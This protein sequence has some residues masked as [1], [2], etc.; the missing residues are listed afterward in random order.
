[1]LDRVARYETM[2][3]AA[4]RRYG[5]WA[6]VLSIRPR[7]PGYQRETLRA[8][9][10]QAVRQLEAE[11]M[12][13]LFSVPGWFWRERRLGPAEIEPALADRRYWRPRSCSVRKLVRIGITPQGWDAFERGDFGEAMPVVSQRRIPW[14]PG[15]AADGSDIAA[16]TVVAVLAGIVGGGICGWVFG[17][18]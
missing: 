12:I 8:A 13:Y 9:A 14:P 18:F 6:T 16:A 7:L 3:M 11:G 10:V 17:S 4:D 15:R 1:M 2:R 5:L